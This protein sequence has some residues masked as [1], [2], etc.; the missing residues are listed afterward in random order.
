MAGALNVFKTITA[1]LTTTMTSVY[2]TPL[3]YSTVV[4]MAQITN[5]DTVN[6]IQVSA[7]VSR[8]AGSTALIQNAKVPVADAITVVTGRLV[9]EP[10]DSFAVS[11]SANSVAQL[12]LSVLE[13]L[14]G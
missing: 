12:T 5:I 11:A 3:G 1:N 10:F 7:N 9:L 8:T 2:A 6:T 4:L 13:S 14:S